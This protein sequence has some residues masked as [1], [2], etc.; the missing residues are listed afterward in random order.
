LIENSIFEKAKNKVKTEFLPALIDGKDYRFPI[1]TALCGIRSN[2]VRPK[3]FDNYNIAF[4]Y[5]KL[6]PNNDQNIHTDIKWEEKDELLRIFVRELLLIIKCDILYRNGDLDRTQII[7]FRPLSFTGTTKSIY[8]DIWYGTPGVRK[9]EPENILFVQPSQIQ[10]YSE[11]EAP[12]YFFK[13]KNII[14]NS[15]AVTVIDIGGGSTDFVY[16]KD[17]EPK[18]AS[19]VHFGCDVLWDNGFI[20][21]D[22]ARENGIYKKYASTLR[23]DKDELNDINDSMK[24]DELVKTKDIINFWLSNS[25][26]C[27]IIK[28]LRDEFKPVFIYHLTSILFYMSCMYKD[29][30]HLAPKTIVFS[31][32]GSK[33]ID[34]FISI[35]K[36]AVK[37]IVDLVFERVFGGEHNVN[38]E[39]PQERKEST[40]YGG[41]YRE[42]NAPHVPEFVYQGDTSMCFENVGEIVK[43][44]DL[45][46]RSLM[47][48]YDALGVL[49]KDVLNMLKKERIIDSTAN[50]SIYVNK[51]TEDM[52]TPLDTYFKTQVK[53]KYQD[54]VLLNDSVFFLPIINR[55]FELTKI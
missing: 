24:I 12:Y 40:C 28:Q 30:G 20:D 26:N 42:P 7:W 45:L 9:G 23:F 53:E 25:K 35:D 47:N 10:C 1:R 18:L 55:I 50:T 2:T 41:L 3:L 14:A 27:D 13:K 54:E 11:S 8:D 17:N 34:S 29:K 32:N 16:F 5:E 15:D 22:N 49:Y 36:T 43:N 6:L 37:R 48:K 31:G 51:V 46:K 19:S 39:L 38:V 44:Y 21:F 33:Y 4:F 52:G